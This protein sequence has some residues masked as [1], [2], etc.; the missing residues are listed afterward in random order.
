MQ[1]GCLEILFIHRF[2]SQEAGQPG[3]LWVTDLSK[4][5]KRLKEGGMKGKMKGERRGWG[6]IDLENRVRTACLPNP[7]QNHILVAGTWIYL[8]PSLW[9]IAPWNWSLWIHHCLMAD[10][11]SSPPRWQGR[12]YYSHLYR[13]MYRGH[14]WT[15]VQVTIAEQW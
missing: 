4:S 12:Y 7:E 5:L 15:N 6:W 10:C 8:G 11:I 2:V 14:Q 9:G 3:P 1:I 13:P